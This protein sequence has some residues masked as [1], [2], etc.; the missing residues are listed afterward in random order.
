MK[1]PG[2]TLPRRPTENGFVNIHGLLL[3]VHCS[4]FTVLLCVTHSTA[5]LTPLPASIQF[6][7]FFSTDLSVVTTTK[8]FSQNAAGIRL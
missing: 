3:C 1:A 8:L 7:E 6:H 5:R 2:A 4:L